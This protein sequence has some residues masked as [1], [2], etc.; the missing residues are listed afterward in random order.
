M[1]VSK[2]HLLRRHKK[3]ITDSSSWLHRQVRILI[4]RN[5]I[6]LSVHTQTVSLHT[7]A[8]CQG[9]SEEKQISER[10]EVSYSLAKLWYLIDIL[11]VT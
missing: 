9:P 2:S 3:I 4:Y 8:W 1:N 6:K 11:K 5:T 7:G 10:Q